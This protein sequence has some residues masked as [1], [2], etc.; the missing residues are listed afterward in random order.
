[1]LSPDKI[2]P[3]IRSIRIS[4][5][6]S[7]EYMAERL[8]ISQ[9]TYA[10]LEAGKT[11]MRVDRLLEILSIL[12]VDIAALFHI[13]STPIIPGREFPERSIHPEVKEVYEKLICEMKDEITF[14]KDLIRSSA[15]V[16]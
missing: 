3:A 16:K 7:Q 1:M 14:L 4:K 12:E 15:Q 13:D 5:E 10:N 9:S 11:A 6:Y 2:G 8:D